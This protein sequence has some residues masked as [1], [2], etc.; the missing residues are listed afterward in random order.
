[1]R[2]FVILG[3]INMA[4]AVAMGAFGA[5]GLEGRV[6]EKMI[7]RWETGAHYHIIHALALVVIGLLIAKFSGQTNMMQLAGWFLFIGIILFSGSL[8]VMTLTGITKLGMITPLGGT[9]FIIGWLLVAVAAWKAS[10]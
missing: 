4:L 2:L 8:Y 9:S 7:S 6:A 1:M 5:H 10:M 3:A